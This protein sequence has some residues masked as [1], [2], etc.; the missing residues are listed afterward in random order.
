MSDY[1]YKEKILSMYGKA[2][3]TRTY[4]QGVKV[5]RNT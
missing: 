1:G 4:E 3:P 2:R 5:R